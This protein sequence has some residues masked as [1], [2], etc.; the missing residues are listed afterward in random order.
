VSRRMASAGQAYSAAGGSGS[1][2]A[3]AGEDDAF[4]RHW[5]CLSVEDEKGRE[6]LVMRLV[7][8]DIPWQDRRLA[9]THDDLRLDPYGYGGQVV[10]AAVELASDMGGLRLV[11]DTALGDR[12]C[13]RVSAGSRVPPFKPGGVGRSSQAV[14]DGYSTETASGKGALSPSTMTASNIG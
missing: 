11:L 4:Y 3:V 2:G 10:R 9:V 13:G 7:P 1:G 5:T 12:Y 8:L 6:T 14:S